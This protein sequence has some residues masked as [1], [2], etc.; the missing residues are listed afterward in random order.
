MTARRP[1]DRKAQ[2]RAVAGEMFLRQGYHNVSVA[3]VADALGITASALYYHYRDK[4]ELLLNAVLDGLDTV[5]AL[6]VGAATLGDALQAL[7]E[8]VCGPR[9]T[10]A[11]WEREARNLDDAQ[12]ELTRAREAEVAAHLTPLL[13]AERRDLAGPDAELLA[14]AVLG[15][16]GSRSRHRIFLPRRRDEQL[17][18]HLASLTARC[19]LRQLDEPQP[20]PRPAGP[21]APE[22]ATGLTRLRRS[23]RDQILNKAIRL[24]DERGYQSV[25][26]ADIGEAAG[27]VASG[28]YRHFPSKSDILAAAMNRGAQRLRDRAD[29]ALDQARTPDE[30]LESLLRAH[31]D[32]V[33]EGIRLVGLLTHERDQLPDKERTALRRMQA[34]YLDIWVQVLGEVHPGCEP[35]ELRVVIH[36]VHSMIYFVLRARRAEHWPHVRERLAELSRQLLTAGLGCP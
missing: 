35:S 24:I 30:A 19:P 22:S 21:A 11:I 3:E 29:Q 5:D 33:S 7:T 10:L 20:A 14:W 12:R 18:F 32:T 13:H 23:R 6:I 2:I 25:T 9:R 1:A 17:M 4:Q 34:D 27:I 31:I 16:L 28:V 8:L 15:V 36:A 26:M